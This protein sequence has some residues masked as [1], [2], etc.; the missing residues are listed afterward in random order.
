MDDTRTRDARAGRPRPDLP[1]SLA[2]LYD[3]AGDEQG[4]SREPSRA[5]RPGGRAGTARTASP[6]GAGPRTPR[7]SP[8]SCRSLRRRPSCPAPTRT[9]SRSL[10]WSRRTLSWRP[11]PG[12]GRSSSPPSRRTPGR[13]HSR[14]SPP[15]CAGC[16]TPRGSPRPSGRFPRRTG[17]R[18]PPSSRG[19]VPRIPRTPASRRASPSPNRPSRRLLL[20]RPG[21]P[22]HGHGGHA[23]S[24]WR[25]RTVRSSPSSVP[26][27]PRPT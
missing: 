21:G 1:E 8:R 17:R 12:P 11:P 13:N 7:R 6:R 25:L 23:G 10:P 26:W 19:S 9:P 16:S 4:L 14:W 18:S 3:Q 15:H 20:R 5:V 27:T 22:A 24:G 2:W